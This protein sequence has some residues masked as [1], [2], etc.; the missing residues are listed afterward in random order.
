MRGTPRLTRM[1]KL[2]RTRWTYRVD[3]RKVATSPWRARHPPRFRRCWQQSQTR[4]QR[5]SPGL[6]LR[7][8]RLLNPIHTLWVCI[9]PVSNTLTRQPLHLQTRQMRSFPLAQA[10][11][12]QNRIWTAWK[13]PWRT[14][15][16]H[17]ESWQWPQWPQVLLLLLLS[18]TTTI[19]VRATILHDKARKLPCR[20]TYRE[21][22]NTK[23]R[24][25]HPRPMEPMEPSSSWKTAKRAHRHYPLNST[26]R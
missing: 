5:P 12:P 9:K 4:T 14:S 16:Q 6:L 1:K 15:S 26:L 13:L 20:T 2:K 17:I 25:R 23:P 18:E 7:L 8:L 24:T 21:S 3:G 11:A 22:K 10:D 19:C